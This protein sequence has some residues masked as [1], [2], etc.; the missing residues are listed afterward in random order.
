VTGAF[1]AGRKPEHA[2]AEGIVTEQQRQ[3]VRELG[4]TEMQSYLFSP[5]R[6]LDE[7]KRL[8]LADLEASA[9]AT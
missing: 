3:M 8:F 2:E 6:P 5:P 9:E 1:A 7:I 4:C